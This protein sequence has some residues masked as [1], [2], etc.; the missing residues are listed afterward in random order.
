MPLA[1]T[2]AEVAAPGEVAAGI[3]GE[4]ALAVAAGVVEW[5]LPDPAPLGARWGEHALMP[6]VATKK[7]PTSIFRLFLIL[8]IVTPSCW[9]C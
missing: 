1:K 2:T 9:A 4:L 5:L 3:A 7:R 6:S 8:R